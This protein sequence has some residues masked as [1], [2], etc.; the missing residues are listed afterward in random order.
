[1]PL[2]PD[3]TGSVE[4]LKLDAHEIPNAPFPYGHKKII[5]P[6]AGNGYFRDNVQLVTRFMG[7]EQV[8][9]IDEYLTAFD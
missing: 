4:G 8:E 9:A 6:A 1:L 3:G 2:R 7:R 5:D